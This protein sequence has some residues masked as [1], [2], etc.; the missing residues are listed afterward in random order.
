MS[1]GESVGMDEQEGSEDGID[2]EDD[3]KG[4]GKGE[5]SESEEELSLQYEEELSK[6]I[7]GHASTKPRAS[8]ALTQGSAPVEDEEKVSAHRVMLHHPAPAHFDF[9]KLDA[10]PSRGGRHLPCSRCHTKSGAFTTG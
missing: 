7:T 4:N 1:P 6:E 10:F 9:P 3:E 8:R 5:E 2:G